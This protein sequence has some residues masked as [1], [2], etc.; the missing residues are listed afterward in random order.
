MSPMSPR[1][2]FISMSYTYSRSIHLVTPLSPGSHQT[3]TPFKFSWLRRSGSPVSHRSHYMNQVK[4]YPFSDVLCPH[5]ALGA[6]SCQC[7]IHIAVRCTICPHWAPGH[8]ASMPFTFSYFGRSRSPVSHWSHYMNHARIYPFSDD[9]WLQW[10]LGATSYECHIHLAV[11]CTMCPHWAPGATR[12]QHPLHLAISDVP[13][14]L[15]VIET[16][17]WIT[18]RSIHFSDVSCP[19]W[20][21]GATSYQCHINIAVGCIM[22]PHWAPGATRFQNPL[23]SANSDVLGL[24]WAIGATI[25]TTSRS[26]HFQTFFVPNAPWEPLHIN[27]LYI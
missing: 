12:L 27:V 22:C 3:S 8:L 25:W 14:P 15:W 6:T 24:M 26:I 20:A 17:L 13:G 21:L 4:I 7:H 19:Q 9:L 1:S 5:W 2:H 11:P 18:P 10:A 23:H 16:T